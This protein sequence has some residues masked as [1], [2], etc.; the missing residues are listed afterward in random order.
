MSHFIDFTGTRAVWQ[1]SRRPADLPRDEAPA[2]RYRGRLSEA[3]VGTGT[4]LPIL[5]FVVLVLG[6]AALTWQLFIP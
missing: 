3:E 6:V 2:V 5:L 4:S 1:Q